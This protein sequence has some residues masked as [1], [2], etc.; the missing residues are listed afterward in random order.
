MM[1]TIEQVVD[2][3]GTGLLN[4]ERN[5]LLD[6][7]T[8][9]RG[10]IVMHNNIGPSRTKWVFTH[11]TYCF[12][13]ILRGIAQLENHG[14]YDPSLNLDTSVIATIIIHQINQDRKRFKVPNRTAVRLCT[15][16]QNALNVPPDVGYR[17]RKEI[18]WWVDQCPH[19]FIGPQYLSVY[20]PRMSKPQRHLKAV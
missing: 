11:M 1:T 20:K 19:V 7:E 14:R 6:S 5:Q 10:L 12:F 4:Y 18:E 17:I 16:T 2:N 15:E 8:L 9:R 3:L 13:T